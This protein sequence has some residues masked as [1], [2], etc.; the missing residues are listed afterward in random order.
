MQKG[1]SAYPSWVEVTN[2]GG[3]L[4]GRFQGRYGHVTAL[5][6]ITLEADGFSFAW[7]SEDPNR[8]PTLF[9]GTV[10]GGRLSGI[11]TAP[12][13]LETPFTGVRA[14]TLARSGEPRWG[15]PIDLLAGG[16]A[17]WRPREPGEN[18]SWTLENGVL[19]NPRPDHDLVTLAT[20]T[21]FKLHLEFMVPEHGN[22]GV[23][24][25]GRHEVQVEDSYGGQPD[26]LRLGGIYGQVTP[27]SLPAKKFGEWQ[28]FDIT[29]VGRTVTVA[30]NG[31][32]IIDRREI[33]GITGGALDSEEGKPGPLM[34]QGDHTAV[35]YR[36]IV[37]T[38]AVR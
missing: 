8:K 30:L 36:N 23:Y 38:P 3:G 20:F 10:A 37:L 16:L 22:S 7:P 4:M 26:S 17:N 31:V 34:L 33:P 6:D 12:S 5:A 2:G 19:I 35:S 32:M 27:S 24:L 14:P 28:S 1:D 29:L 15:R 21:D 9:A 11:M 25:R 18:M 13:G